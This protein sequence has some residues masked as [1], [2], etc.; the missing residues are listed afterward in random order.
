MQAL[1]GQQ[2]ALTQQVQELAQ[3]LLRL[4]AQPVKQQPTPPWT[5]ASRREYLPALACVGGALA[6]FTAMKLWSHRS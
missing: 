5:I 3:A 4:E 6:M 1:V 2:Q